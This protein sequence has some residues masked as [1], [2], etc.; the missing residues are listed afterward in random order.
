VSSFGHS[1]EQL[2]AI[3]GS[4]S[5]ATCDEHRVATQVKCRGTFADMCMRG[6]TRGDEV[7]VTPS[8]G[9]LVSS[10]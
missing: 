9:G 7:I 2:D 10:R 3:A 6:A 5:V 1:I 8:F 4:V